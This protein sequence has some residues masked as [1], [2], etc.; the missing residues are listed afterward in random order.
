M[1]KKR[2]DSPDVIPD[3]TTF[4]SA[5]SELESVLERMETGQLTLEESLGAYR[6]G[7]ALVRH[8]QA[9]LEDAD[10][11]LKILEDGSLK[12]FDLDGGADA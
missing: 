4:E 1:K 9:Q 5:L 12:T 8:C 7:A 11:R 10:A 2:S 3:D 6:R